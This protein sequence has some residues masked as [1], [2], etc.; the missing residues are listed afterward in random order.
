MI[1]LKTRV[2][3]IQLRD[4]KK[5]ISRLKTTTKIN[6]R[7]ENPPRFSRAKKSADFADENSPIYIRP[8]EMIYRNIKTARKTGKFRS[9]VRASFLAIES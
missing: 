3:R 7:S 5:I 2:H 1:T 9:V 8:S 4:N 6:T